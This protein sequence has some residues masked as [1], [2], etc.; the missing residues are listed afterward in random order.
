M[1]F[2]TT[3][4]SAGADPMSE[5]GGGAVPP[6]AAPAT[7]TGG[8]PKK[9]KKSKKSKKSKSKSKSGD[10]ATTSGGLKFALEPSR[11]DELKT[12]YE[13]PAGPRTRRALHKTTVIITNKTVEVEREGANVAMTI[14]TLG[15]WYFCFQTASIEIYELNRITSLYLKDDVIVGEVPTKGMCSSGRFEIDLPPTAEKTTKDLF[16]ELKEVWN[17]ANNYSNDDAAIDLADDD[18]ADEIDPMVA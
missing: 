6:A 15:C 9:A 11:I 14:L 12:I 7:G 4:L 5:S 10:T 18:D 2:A 1:L 13:G 3:A 8:T 16:F 17:R